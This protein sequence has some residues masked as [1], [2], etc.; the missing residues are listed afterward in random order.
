MFVW[1]LAEVYLHASTT[2]RRTAGLR[3]EQGACQF[4]QI[5]TAGFG[6]CDYASDIID[7]SYSHKWYIHVQGCLMMSFIWG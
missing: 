1:C 3:P 6:F 4:D 2:V 5:V 7:V